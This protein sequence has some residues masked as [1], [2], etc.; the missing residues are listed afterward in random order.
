[1]ANGKRFLIFRFSFISSPNLPLF[2][3][4]ELVGLTSALRYHNLKSGGQQQLFP[5][6]LS[7]LEWRLESY[8]TIPNVSLFFTTFPLVPFFPL[9]D[10][11]PETIFHC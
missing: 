5:G 9:F 8:S 1:M 10:S 3:L 11:S 6:S 4:L 7:G 2:K